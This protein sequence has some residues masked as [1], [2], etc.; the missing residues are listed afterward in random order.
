MIKAIHTSKE[1]KRKKKKPKGSIKKLKY[2]L[3][4]L[5]ILVPYYVKP[6]KKCFRLVEG[7]TW[8][9]LDVQLEFDQQYGSND[10]IKI[11]KS[12]HRMQID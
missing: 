9:V 1:N 12:K 4:E 2:K 11:K 5:T 3:T 7:K 6:I 10:K 8:K